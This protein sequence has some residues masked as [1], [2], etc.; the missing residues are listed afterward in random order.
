TN[1]YVQKSSSLDPIIQGGTV[2]VIDTATNTIVATVLLGQMSRPREVAITPD[3]T[4][5]YVT[6]TGIVSTVFVIDTATN[7]RVANVLV[8]EDPRG[9][10]ITPDGTLAYVAHRGRF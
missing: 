10:A 5:A 4:H 8:G 6:S 2:K 7:T 9:V 1:A 3:G